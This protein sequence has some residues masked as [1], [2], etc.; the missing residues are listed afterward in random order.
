MEER[1]LPVF[2]EAE[3]TPATKRVVNGIYIV[4]VQS[5]CCAV[6]IVVFWLFSL[7]G[8]NGYT[9]LCDAFHGALQN[10]T[11]FATVATLF[12]QTAP[13]ETYTQT[14]GTTTGTTTATTSATTA[15]TSGADE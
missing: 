9:Q 14:T 2:E 6:L 8:G 15:A 3:K 5:A 7:V 11:L 4:L 10:N 13:D 1:S 12:E